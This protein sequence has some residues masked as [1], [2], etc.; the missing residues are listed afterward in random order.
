M[1]AIGKGPTRFIHKRVTLVTSCAHL[2]R[3][4]LAIVEFIFCTLNECF[5]QNTS[6]QLYFH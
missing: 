6:C 3:D 5:I 1:V 2:T 4:L